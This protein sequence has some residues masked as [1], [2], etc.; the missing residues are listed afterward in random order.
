MTHPS[1]GFYSA[2][3]AD[4]EGEEGKFYTWT[5]KEIDA[6]LGPKADIFKKYYHVN[7]KGLWEEGLNIILRTETEE[8]FA[9]SMSV[10]KSSLVRLL[11]SSRKKL[12][13]A[14][15]K[16]IRPGLDDKII[17]SWN[18]LMIKGYVDAYRAF[19]DKDYLDT[20]TKAASFI[21]ADLKQND[22]GLSRTWKNG[23]TR[24]N[25]FLEDYSFFCL[26]L[27]EL[28]QATFDESWLM[29]AEKLAFY[30][31]DHFSGSGTPLLYFTSHSDQE[32]IVRRT[33]IY[34]NVIPSS[35]SVMANVFFTL[36]ILLD[37]QQFSDRSKA[38]SE[39]ISGTMSRF[40]SAFSNWAMLAMSMTGNYYAVV[41]AGEEMQRFSR[42]VDD[43][44]YPLKVMA[45]SPEAG[46]L[47]LFQNRYVK[48]Q[49]TIY[50][51]TG[52]ECRL[53]VI[54]PEAAVRLMIK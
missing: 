44:Y 54:S 40:P 12:L 11:E 33:D 48:G 34:D 53:P 32:L 25:G 51:C 30:T 22:G 37:N 38:M 52:N 23:Q 19:H 14:R 7:G 16:R 31:L 42:E 9:R 18:A 15:N 24:I 26:A 39:K 6:I 20:A 1:G 49:T 21:I 47:P 2:L 27:I 41:I 43:F 29:E 13:K 17:T 35:N 46:T 3:D 36:G 10:D 50:V 4:A 28:Y 5:E 45:G 8:E